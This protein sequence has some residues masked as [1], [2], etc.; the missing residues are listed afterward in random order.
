VADS[1]FT[2]PIPRAA[3]AAGAGPALAIDEAQHNFHTAGGRYYAVAQGAGAHRVRMG[4]NDPGSPRNPQFVRA[5]L[6]WLAEGH[7]P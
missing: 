4:M 7:C 2:P 3:F 6:R 5:V 1:A